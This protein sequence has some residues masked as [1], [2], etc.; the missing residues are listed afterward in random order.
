MAHEP[1]PI[2]PRPTAPTLRGLR[3]W[4][5]ILLFSGLAVSVTSAAM[6]WFVGH[7]VQ[8]ALLQA[9]QQLQ[10]AARAV[11]LLA[12]SRFER[13]RGALLE[14]VTTSSVEHGTAPALSGARR[15]GGEAFALVL[16]PDGAL[17]VVSG[18]SPAVS[19]QRLAAAWPITS[20]L[21]GNA[22]RGLWNLDGKL[23]EV[24]ALPLPAKAGPPAIAA[25]VIGDEV[26]DVVDQIQAVTG[27]EV[28]LLAGD[29]LVEATL[30]TE[31]VPPALARVLESTFR[32]LAESLARAEDERETSYRE[33]IAAVVTALDTRDHG[34]YGHS[35]RVAAY[36][37]LLGERVGL[38]ADELCG[39]E[40]GALLHDVGKIAVPDT[41]LQKAAPLEAAEWEVMRRHTEWG[42]S[43]VSR[44]AFLRSALPVV[45]SHH[46]RW[47]G[48]G[49]PSQLEGTT[50]P[51][52]ARIF[53]VVDAYDAMTTLYRRR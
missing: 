49:Y 34:T 6:L 4:Q 13:R 15:P 29:R 10:R 41:I 3:L 35:L 2:S 38:P 25:A 18:R 9:S 26:A 20:A 47:D 50:I 11:E 23:F 39:L 33:A 48:T 8:A 43:I 37:R 52:A 31:L 16:A 30:P 27:A 5:Q 46:E 44:V 17:R 45:E 51:M 21:E 36:A 28:M 12:E 7:R 32:R 53:A 14:W 24:F 42:R 40:W 22:G 1:K 19:P